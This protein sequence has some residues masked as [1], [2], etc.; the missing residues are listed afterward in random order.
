MRVL[1]VADSDSYLKWA[2]CLLGD[3]PAGCESELV[4]VRTAD[5]PVAG[6][7]RRRRRRASAAAGRRR[8]GRCAARP[9]GPA[10]T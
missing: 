2:A 8:R 6:A 9:N 1:A 3:L 5:R 7:D 4:V 10:P